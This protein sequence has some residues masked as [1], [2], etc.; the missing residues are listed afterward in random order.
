MTRCRMKLRNS[1][2]LEREFDYLVDQEKEERGERRGLEQRAAGL[3]GALLVALPVS[4]TVAKDADIDDGLRLA[5]LI[6]LGCV[7]IAAVTMAWIVTTAIGAPRRKRNVVRKAR[8]GVSRALGRN[9]L[10]RAV[11][12]QLKIITTMRDDNALLVRD[13]RRATR[14]LPAMLAGLLVALA[15]LVVGGDGDTDDGTKPPDSRQGASSTK[16]GPGTHTE[17]VPRQR[18]QTSPQ[19]GR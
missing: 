17:T 12:A 10:D 13:V 14:A 16:T 19:G 11:K 1:S 8:E 5:G 6:L 4:G 18:R 7:L 15:L 3:I 9:R 2:A